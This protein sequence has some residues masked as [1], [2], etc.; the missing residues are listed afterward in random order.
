MLLPN[1]SKENAAK[2]AERIRKNIE[3]TSIDIGDRELNVTASLGVASY[4]AENVSNI[5]DLLKKADEALYQAK[6]QS[7]NAVVVAD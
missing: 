4:P 5:N 3:D 1:T 7:R 6:E 2:I